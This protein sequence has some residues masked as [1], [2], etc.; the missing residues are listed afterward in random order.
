MR[1]A[2]ARAKAIRTIGTTDNPAAADRILG[3]D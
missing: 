3:E 1:H 2:T